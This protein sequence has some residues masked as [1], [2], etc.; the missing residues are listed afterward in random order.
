MGNT[1]FARGIRKEITELSFP[2]VG[3]KF[4]AHRRDIKNT[5]GGTMPY[6]SLQGES[7]PDR[8][9]MKVDEILRTVYGDTERHIVKMASCASQKEDGKRNLTSRY[10]TMNVID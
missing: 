9:E 6:E 2:S 7:Q 10:S 3:N 8:H 4:L 5:G 1:N